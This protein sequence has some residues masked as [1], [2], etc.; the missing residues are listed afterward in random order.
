M[1][2]KADALPIKLTFTV[3]RAIPIF[4]SLQYIFS[5]TYV[6]TTYILENKRNKIVHTQALLLE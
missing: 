6:F 4:T 3:Q 2:N 5:Q 1:Y